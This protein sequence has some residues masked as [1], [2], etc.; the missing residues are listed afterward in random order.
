MS[1][2][3]RARYGSRGSTGPNGS[4]GAIGSTTSGNNL[5][6]KILVA[7]IVIMLA[8]G[9]WGL[10][11]LFNADTPAAEITLLSQEYPDD[12]TLRVWVDITRD[13]PE[14]PAYCI[15]QAF[16]YEKAEVGRVEIPMAPGEKRTERLSVDVPVR[17]GEKAVAGGVYGCSGTIPAHLKLGD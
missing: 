16:N 1:T 14:V 2:R 11:R 4:E 7:I 17:A 8:L 13:D 3:K 15:V 10:F 9:S 12:D 5:A 6:G